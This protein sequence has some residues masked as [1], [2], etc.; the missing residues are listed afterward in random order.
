MKLNDGNEILIRKATKRDAQEA[1]DYLNVVGGE[2][3]NLLFGANEMNFT[4]EQ[5][6]Q[7]IE[8]MNSSMTSVLLVGIVNDK[9]VCIGSLSTP[10]RER[11]SHRG[12]I[13]MSVLKEF[14]GLGIGTH[15][16]N[17][18]INF[19]NCSGKLEILHLG[20][21]ADNTRAIKL[22]EKTGFRKTGCVPRFFKINSAYYDEILMDFNL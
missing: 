20:V 16:M 10:F 1:L 11:I 14:W 15:L 7:F 12:E 21:K 18:L 4:L 19:A 2:S 17:E 9:I 3:D 13:A 5:E 6:E 22:Y 8:S